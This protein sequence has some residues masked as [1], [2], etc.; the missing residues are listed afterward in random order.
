MIK[1]EMNAMK[2]Y[3]LITKPDD[4]SEAEF[5]AS[6]IESLSAHSASS[7]LM[8]IV[9]SQNSPNI[10]IIRG[11]KRPAEDFGYETPTRSLTAGE[12]R[13]L[14]IELDK[15]NIGALS[16]N[17][18]MLVA[19]SGMKEDSTYTKPVSELSAIEFEQHISK[20]FKAIEEKGAKVTWNSTISDPFTP[21]RKRQIDVLIEKGGKKIH[22][23][24][25]HRGRRQNVNWIEEL[26]G[27]GLAQ[28]A[29]LM[30]GISSSGFSETAVNTAKGLGVRLKEIGSIDKNGEFWWTD[31]MFISTA[32]FKL[33]DIKLTFHTKGS[34]IPEYH[35]HM[36]D[37]IT[38]KG[39]DTWDAFTFALDQFSNKQ[40]G[41]EVF[42]N[43]HYLFKYSVKP[44][45]DYSDLFSKIDVSTTIQYF[46]LTATRVDSHTLNDLSQEIDTL[47]AVIENREMLGW[48]IE[49]ISSEDKLKF[50][51]SKIEDDQPKDEYISSA[52][53]IEEVNLCD[54]EVSFEV[55]EQKKKTF[56][57]AHTRYL[58]Y[59]NGQVT[60]LN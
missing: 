44:P 28:K 22:V 29:D 57:F 55:E 37:K 26:A 25:R 18:R 58:Q 59:S 54:K 23:E 20:V 2:E 4:I 6:A 27:K 41:V 5:I 1:A 30:I 34:Q 56:Y 31:G 21:K 39:S 35:L 60:Q 24:C 7:N 46:N 16:I 53:T 51:C 38:E 32:K 49:V 10:Y 9:L 17:P 47:D 11:L 48:K 13:A 8:P 12:L 40:L 36:I 19:N 42:E 52:I 50:I 43:R 14:R 15:G 3:T 45:K 33:Q